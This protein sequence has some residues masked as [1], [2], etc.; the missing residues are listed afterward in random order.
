MTFTNTD[1]VKWMLLRLEIP[2]QVHREVVHVKTQVYVQINSIQSKI[3]K[4][5]HK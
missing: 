1:S 5:T 2:K 4:E 3:E